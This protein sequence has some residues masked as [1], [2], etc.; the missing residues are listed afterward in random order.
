MEDVN[1]C[2]TIISCKT[3][4][5]ERKI[6]LSLTQTEYILKD[7]Q[8][9]VDFQSSNFLS[10]SSICFSCVTHG[11]QRTCRCIARFLHSNNIKPSN[12]AMPRVDFLDQLI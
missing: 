7:F 4:S 9:D 12:N 5:R 11:L 10:Y 2:T 3:T 6:L 8:S 1:D